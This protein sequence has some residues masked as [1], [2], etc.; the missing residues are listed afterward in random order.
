MKARSSS[1]FL[2]LMALLAMACGGL[3]ADSPVN[4]L[5]SEPREAVAYVEVRAPDDLR[6]LLLKVA[7]SP[8][9]D[10][11]MRESFI[12]YYVGRG[13]GSGFVV[14]G[15]KAGHTRL[16]TN[17]HVADGADY[18]SVSFDGNKTM[19]RGDIVHI[20]ADYDLAIVDLPVARP[21]LQLK[22]DVNELEQVRSVG[23]PAVSHRG[24]YQIATGNVTNACLKGDIIGENP[25]NCWIQHS[26]P[27]DPGSSGGPLLSA[28]SRVLGVNTLLMRRRNSMFLSIPAAHVAKALARGDE[29]LA[30]RG[31][32]AWMT[33]QLQRSCYS[34]SSELSAKNPDLDRVLGNMSYKLVVR[35]GLEAFDEMS[36][37]TE[38][39]QLKDY[40]EDDPLA[41]IQLS[42]TAKLREEFVE[43]G[44]IK[45][46]ER[47]KNINPNDDASGGDDVRIDL[48]MR[49]G[50]RELLFRFERGQWR[51]SGY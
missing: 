17:R 41:A 49:D 29:I 8:K 12:A 20:D 47:C 2:F 18:V 19:I 34:L 31:D 9:V 13:S 46:D 7:M 6:M 24:S 21:G 35:K 28:D 45:P 50:H 51:L 25:N 11:N 14:A 36:D 15:G 30:K 44:G 27:I 32:K 48:E 10:E 37:S 38:A 1:F 3:R 26:A 5:A 40:L 33:E 16:V 42:I 23:Y 22:T 43:L 39:K 4:A